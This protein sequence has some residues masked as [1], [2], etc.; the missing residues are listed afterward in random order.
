MG[1]TQRN[2]ERSLTRNGTE[3]RGGLK[4]GDFQKPEK[5][6]LGE[7]MVKMYQVLMSQVRY[8]LRTAY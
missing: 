5:E 7:R 2:Q 3:A 4:E 6:G 8:W 1:K